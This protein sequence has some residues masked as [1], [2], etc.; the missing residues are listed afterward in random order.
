MITW[1]QYL[2]D[3]LTFGSLYAVS[4]L[5]I[6]LIFGVVRIAN[7]AH[8]EIIMLSCYVLLIFAGAFWPLAAIPVLLAGIVIAMSMERFAFRRVRKADPIVLLIVSFALGMLLRNLV[9]L[10]LGGESR[11]VQFGQSLLQPV[12][13]GSLSTSLSNLVTIGVTFVLLIAISQFLK[14]TKMGMQLRAASEDFSMARMVGV[15]ANRV[16]ATAFGLSG[17]LGALAGLMY[18][19]QSGSLTP[20]MGFQPVLVAFVATVIGGMGSITGAVV[21]GYLVGAMTGLLG[22]ILPEPLVPFRDSFVFGAVILVLLLRPQGLFSKATAE[23]R[24]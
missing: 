4:A 9:V 24:I 16:V 20:Q 22:V 23:D 15:K 18:T 8:A 2:I 7:F 19:V 10:V 13:F 1:L 11:S 17:F 12:H 6:A 5:G 21:G 3:S 14:R